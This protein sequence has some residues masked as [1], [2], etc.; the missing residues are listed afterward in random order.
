M[1]VVLSLVGTRP[2]AIKMAPVIR[3]LRKYPE[4]IKSLVC[5]TGQHREMLD[6]VLNLFDIRPDYDL[7]IM[8][9]DQMLSR[10]TASLFARLDPV[11]EEIRPD[12]IIAEGDTTTVLVAALVSYYRRIRFGHVEAG[13]RTGD[14]FRPYPEEI[15]RR[16]ADQLGDALFAPTERSR[17]NLLREGVPE[18]RIL[19]TGNTVIDALLAVT[20]CPYD[21]SASPLAGL[22]IDRRLVLITA[23]RR[24]SFGAALREICFAIKELASQ[25]ES[26]G[27]HFVYPV[28]L[29]PNVCRPVKEI[30]S[31][32]PNVSLIEPLDYLSMVQLMK[33]STLILTDSGGIQEEAPSLGVPVLVMRETTERPE[34][35]EAGVARLVGTRRDRIVEETA[36]LLQDSVAY[37]AMVTRVNPYGDGRAAARIVS[38]LLKCSDVQAGLT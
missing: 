36:H 6:Q 31:G 22:P 20:A 25:L 17:K 13:L 32:L 8:E 15:N 21:C 18:E 16:I 1:L 29:N 10:L 27:F 30:L 23:H 9:P 7:K 2:E 11:V 37:Q 26:Q 34:G 12:W 19:V 5:A 38:F 4:R 3:E 28:H 24:E 33:R 35:I 14:K